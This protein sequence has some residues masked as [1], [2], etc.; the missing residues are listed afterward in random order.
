MA[1][2]VPSASSHPTFIFLKSHLSDP[3]TGKFHDLYYSPNI[4]RVTKS[5]RMGW[6]GHVARMRKEKNVHKFGRG[7]NLKK[8]GHFGKCKRG[9]EDNTKMNLK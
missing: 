9:R 1:S 2:F 3:P 7:R 5:R 6:N 8:R 4:L